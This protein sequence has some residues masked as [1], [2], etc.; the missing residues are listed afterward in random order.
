MIDIH[1][2]WIYHMLNSKGATE[3]ICRAFFGFIFI[4]EF[5]LEI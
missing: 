4:W 1:K 3:N 5:L 2:K